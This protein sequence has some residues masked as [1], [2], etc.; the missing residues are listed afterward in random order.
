[1]FDTGIDIPGIVNLVIFKPVYS[2][3]KFWEMIGRGTRPY[4]NLFSPGEHKTTFQVFDIYRNFEFF[5]E[6]ETGIEATEHDSITARIS[7]NTLA[8]AVVFSHEPFLVEYHQNLRTKTYN[9]SKDC[10][11]IFNGY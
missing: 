10:Y 1:M 11:L 4:E 7:K 9:F 3:A 6:N 2:K 5:G 8:L